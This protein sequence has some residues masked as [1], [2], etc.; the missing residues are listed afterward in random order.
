MDPEIDTGL[1]EKCVE[2]LYKILHELGY[3]L[4]L[5]CI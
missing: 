4:S 5:Y 3:I 1:I 2:K